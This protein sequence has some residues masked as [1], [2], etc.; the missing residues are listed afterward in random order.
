MLPE[1]DRTT[2][3]ARSIFDPGWYSDIKHTK[4][5]V[6]LMAAGVLFYFDEAQVRPFFS[7]LADNLPGAEIVFDT[8]PKLAVI[9]MNWNVR[10]A[11]MK[12]ATVKCALRGAD[13]ITKWDNRITVINQVPLFRNI[14]RDPLWG[15]GTRRFMDFSDRFKTLN[16]FH[17]RV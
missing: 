7:S 17:L 13:E 5:G 9:F 11:G 2:L 14:P 15:V 6:F 12:G 4:D 10:K 16:I 8:L 1:T 3:I